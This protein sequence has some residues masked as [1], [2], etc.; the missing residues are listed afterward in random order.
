MKI[1]EKYY[2]LNNILNFIKIN[3]FIIQKGT[4]FKLNLLI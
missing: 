2:F 3:F 4:A 1:K